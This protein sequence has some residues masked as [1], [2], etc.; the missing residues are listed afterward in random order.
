MSGDPSLGAAEYVLGTLDAAE[1]AAFAERLARDPQAGFAVFG[2][3][4]LIRF[5]D[6]TPAQQVANTAVVFDYQDTF[7]HDCGFLS[8][9]V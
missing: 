1:R 6:E 3:V 8:P 2:S 4:D 9:R 7:C 5:K